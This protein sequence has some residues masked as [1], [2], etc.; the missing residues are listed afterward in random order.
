M[1]TWRET[2]AIAGRCV[3]RHEVDLVGPFPTTKEGERRNGRRSKSKS[4]SS[5]SGERE[6]ERERREGAER[7]DEAHRE[8]VVVAVL[9]RG[10]SG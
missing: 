2:L 9:V 3:A 6:R 10:M 4:S 8:R 7:R 1:R 5:S